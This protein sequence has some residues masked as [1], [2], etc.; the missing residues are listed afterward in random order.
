MLTRFFEAVSVYL[1]NN[2]LSYGERIF[3]NPVPF[4]V[5][6]IY[7]RSFDNNIS[8]SYPVWPFKTSPTLVV[9][10]GNRQNMLAVTSYGDGEKLDEAARKP[11]D[12]IKQMAGTDNIINL[13]GESS[14][15]QRK[16]MKPFLTDQAAI[17]RVFSEAQLTFNDLFDN[18]DTSIS[19]RD[20][21]SYCCLLLIARCVLGIPSLTR[22]QAGI[23]TKAG[24][25][26]RES[27]PGK[28]DF[29]EGEESLLKLN[30]DLLSLHEDVLLH[31]DNYIHSKAEIADA[32]EQIEKSSKLSK[33]RGVS[34][35]LVESN[36]TML[37]MTGMVYV[38]HSS[39]IK[40]R[41]RDELKGQPD[42]SLEN[43]RKLPYLDYIYK[44]ALRF[45]SPTP[46]I[47]RETSKATNLTISDERGNQKV[48]RVPSHALLF[49]PIRRMHHDPRFWDKPEEFRP[50]RFEDPEAAKH[51]MPYS[52]GSRSCP[53][54]SHFNEIIFK[55][56]I[57][58]SINYEFEL[59]KEIERI[60]ADS[61]TSRWHQE[62]FI[63]RIALAEYHEPSS[64][65]LIHR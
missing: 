59:D 33:T 12:F 8:I 23:I 53:A 18:W 36:L 15:N 48:Y 55:S 49:A 13:I 11:L 63:T 47:I 25:L 5:S 39:A 38:N 26:L 62:Y 51:F 3:F 52:L 20:N 6:H 45:A 30:N 19:L 64:F 10:S 9:V 1:P 60:P 56:A 34:N 50:E 24:N 37:L 65:T 42:F 29:I 4:A 57:L 44:E 27:E 22:E 46:M 35:L 43:M 61:L 31:S 16:K 41:L 17:N 2:M 32:D 28:S 58:A 54:A 21:V 40:A 14:I 7:D